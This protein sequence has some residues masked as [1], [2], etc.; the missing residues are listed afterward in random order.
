MQALPLQAD[1]LEVIGFSTLSTRFVKRRD[2]YF[3]HE[4]VNHHSTCTIVPPWTAFLG[5]ILPVLG[6]SGCFCTGI[7]LD[8]S[9]FTEFT[10]SCAPCF[11][12]FFSCSLVASLI[13]NDSIDFFRLQSF[14]LNNLVLAPLSLQPSTS[15]SRTISSSRTPNLHGS[16]SWRNLITNWSMVSCTCCSVL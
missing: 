13:R 15:R 4:H 16:A 14:S 12:I 1:S 10:G 2:I 9:F 3:Y 6:P 5:L 8:T 7:L 11:C